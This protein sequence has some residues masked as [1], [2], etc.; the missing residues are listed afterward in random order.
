[1]NQ[2]NQDRCS[3]FNLLLESSDRLNDQF[4]HFEPEK[5]LIEDGLTTIYNNGACGKFKYVL[6]FLCAYYADVVDLSHADTKLLVYGAVQATGLNHEDG[7]IFGQWLAKNIKEN[8]FTRLE[9]K[10]QHIAAFLEPRTMTSDFWKQALE[11]FSAE[12][13][14]AKPQEP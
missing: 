13:A 5:Q 3:F 7:Q 6:T 14:S 11:S 1:M 12:T 4:S 9:Q 10:L 8:K 2:D